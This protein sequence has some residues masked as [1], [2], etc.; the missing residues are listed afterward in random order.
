MN[1]DATIGW[2]GIGSIPMI[3]DTFVENVTGKRLTDTLTISKS[4]QP[5]FA[6]SLP[7]VSSIL[8]DLLLKK[9][10]SGSRAKLYAPAT[11]D[12]G[13]SI[14]H[15]DETSTLQSQIHL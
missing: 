1:T 15:L 4:I 9:Y 7:V 8:M 10:T 5:I 14:S 2:Y 12:P 3:Y 13:S 11:W 6:V